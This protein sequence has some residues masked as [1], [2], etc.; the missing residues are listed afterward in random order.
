MNLYNTSKR[1]FD[2]TISMFTLLVVSPVLLAVMLLARV[3][4]GSPIIYKAKRVG[5][6]SKIFT[7]LKFR[8]MT[9]ETDVNGIALPDEQRITKLGSFLRSSSID[10]LPSLLNVIKGD[11][12]LVG[13]RPFSSLYVDR[14]T[15][16][17]NRRH[18]VP[19]GITGWSQVNGRNSLS[20]EEKFEL[21]LWYVENRSFYIDLKILFKTVAQVFSHE[22]ISHDG[23]VSAPEFIGTS[24]QIHSNDSLPDK[25][26]EPVRE[27]AEVSEY[28]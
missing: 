15:E 18:S 28:D 6:N 16:R 22:D 11:L 24:K 7:L 3:K 8:S 5:E 14:Y 23:Y 12:S 26:T 17:Q 20:W 25:R 9:N 27:I 2:I 4:L 10:E 13:P 19:P 1:V 21:D